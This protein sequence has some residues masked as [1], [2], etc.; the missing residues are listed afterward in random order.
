[1]TNQE[2]FAK[3]RPIVMLATGV[4]ECIL[5][6]QAGPDS[7]PAPK[8]AYATITP[9][10]YIGERGQANVTT[11]DILGD[12][13][14]TEVRA[15]IMCSASINFY[16]GEALMYAERLKQANKRPDI[17]IMLFKA[18]IG[19]NSADGV[20]NLTSLQSANFE[21]RSQITLRLMYEAISISEIN[22][23]LSVEVALENEKAQVLQ[24]FTV[25][26]DPS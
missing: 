8:G 18:K 6:D 24:T 20:N 3:L 25:E 5:A 10:Q 14:E 9:R 21:Q 12:L 26:V 2:F 13:V 11:R 16:R 17:S 19:W 23:I 1:M 4:P 15:Q 22:N 7:M